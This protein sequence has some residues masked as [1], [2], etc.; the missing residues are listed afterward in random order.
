[1]TWYVRTSKRVGSI[2]KKFSKKVENLKRLEVILN[3]IIHR[4]SVLQN[5]FIR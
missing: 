4:E 2:F 5:Q 1:M 3:Y